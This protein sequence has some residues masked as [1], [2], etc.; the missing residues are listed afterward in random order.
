MS[1]SSGARRQWAVRVFQKLLRLPVTVSSVNGFFDPVLSCHQTIA[2]S[3][4]SPNRINVETLTPN[5]ILTESPESLQPASDTIEGIT[6]STSPP[7]DIPVEES[8]QA[9]T[10]L[11]LTVQQPVIQLKAEQL[12]EAWK[13]LREIFLSPEAD[14][15]L[16]EITILGEDL[17][18]RIRLARIEDPTSALANSSDSLGGS[19]HHGN[20]RASF[21]SNP[22]ISKGF[23]GLFDTGAEVSLMPVE[24][25]RRL[26]RGFVN[27][28]HL[29]PAHQ[30]YLN[31]GGFNNQR[32]SA[33][34]LIS[35]LW[36]LNEFPDVIFNTAFW[37]VDD[38]PNDLIVGK[39]AMRAIYTVV[40]QQE[41]IRNKGPPGKTKKAFDA[42]RHVS[43]FRQSSIRSLRSKSPL[44][45]TLE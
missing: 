14:S 17:P 19:I 44:E 12:E 43:L 9:A 25:L 23:S 40:K 38:I 27:V 35:L 24:S 32:S 45:K 28:N 4:Y 41:D 13:L 16:G 22:P 37:V 34:G 7:V 30:S 3:G 29:L 31:I 6:D 33:L 2:P 10:S 36:Y 8:P 1:P 5:N 18:D 11:L 39:D 15:S 42:V 21:V 20:V 26:K